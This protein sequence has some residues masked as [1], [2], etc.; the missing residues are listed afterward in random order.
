[1]RARGVFAREGD[2]RG[3]V[4]TE[5]HPYNVAQS[6]DTRAVHFRQG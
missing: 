3:R 2:A 1:M 5:R 4:A 6:L